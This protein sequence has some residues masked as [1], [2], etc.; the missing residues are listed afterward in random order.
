MHL[1]L[2]SCDKVC[3]FATLVCNTAYCCLVQKSFIVSIC[4]KHKLCQKLLVYPRTT[5]RRPS[6]FYQ[7]SKGKQIA[8]DKLFIICRVDKV[9][10]T[11]YFFLLINCTL[12]ILC[13]TFLTRKCELV[14]HQQFQFLLLCNS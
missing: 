10:S 9:P 3:T 6:Y 4:M 1:Y 13:V 12:G 7:R 2:D 5:Q 14:N 11:G 8:F